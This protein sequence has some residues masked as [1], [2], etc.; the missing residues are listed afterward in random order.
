MSVKLSGK[1]MWFALLLP[2]VLY[3]DV[4][5]ICKKTK[6]GCGSYERNKKILVT[7]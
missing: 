4:I 7:F 3:K 5:H 6:N 2:S 1:I